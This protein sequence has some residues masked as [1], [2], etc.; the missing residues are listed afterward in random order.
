MRILF[1]CKYN[2]FRSQIAEAYFRKINKNKNISFSSAGVIIGEPIVDV[3]RQTARKF[4]FL[5][6]GKPK[7][8]E[9][10]LL[11]RTDLVVVVADDVPASLFRTRVKEV[12]EWNIPDVKKP[13]REEIETISRQIMEKVDELNKNLR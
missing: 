10:S 3:V 5:I 6:R 1:V 7:G 4:G 12:F 9:E 11:E 8:I 13:D 2:R